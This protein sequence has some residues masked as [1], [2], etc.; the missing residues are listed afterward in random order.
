MNRRHFLSLLSAGVAGIA[1]E[2]AVPFNRVWSFPKNIINPSRVGFDPASGVD[3]SAVTFR[4]AGDPRLEIGDII[5]IAPSPNRFVITEVIEGGFALAPLPPP[6]RISQY[7][8]FFSQSSPNIKRALRE[9][10]RRTT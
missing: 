2:Q 7:R 8:D 6:L 10:R 9:Y 3:I 1:L 4:P 5:S